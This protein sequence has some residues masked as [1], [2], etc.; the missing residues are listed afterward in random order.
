[1]MVWLKAWPMCKV[2]V[3]FGGSGAERALVQSAISAAAPVKINATCVIAAARL[4]TTPLTL[5]ADDP[6]VIA[7]DW[8][9]AYVAANLDGAAGCVA[10]AG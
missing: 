10:T 3:T 8:Q 1:M 6:P 9:P 5:P 4:R 2:P 7:L